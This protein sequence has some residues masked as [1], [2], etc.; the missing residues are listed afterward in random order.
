MDFYSSPKTLQVMIQVC[1]IQALQ[2]LSLPGPLALPGPLLLPGPAPQLPHPLHR[3]PNYCRS[4]APAFPRSTATSDPLLAFRTT[5]APRPYL[6]FPSAWLILHHVV[7]KGFMSNVHYAGDSQ[8]HLIVENIT[9]PCREPQPPSCR[10]QALCP[11]CRGAQP[12]PSCI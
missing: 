1:I 10:D 2:P 11:S 5:A 8:H 7:E 3:S 6:A 12:P 4:L 9:M